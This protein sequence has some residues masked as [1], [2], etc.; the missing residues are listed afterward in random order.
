MPDAPELLPTRR[1]PLA[2]T[3]AGHSHRKRLD[4]ASSSMTMLGL[5]ITDATCDYGLAQTAG[6]VRTLA[7]YDSSA[8]L[9]FQIG[10]CV[11]G[12]ATLVMSAIMYY[13]AD[14]Y[15]GSPLQLYS[16]LLCCYASLTMILRGAD[17]AS[18][19]HIVPR[20]VS[21]FLSDS[22]TAALYSV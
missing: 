16:F 4:T 5:N 20:P 9:H 18:Y 2:G 10:Y 3:L 8:Y 17:P 21:A 11:V 7:S 1:D 15:D 19:G 22:C 12:A 13:R 6:C 14:K